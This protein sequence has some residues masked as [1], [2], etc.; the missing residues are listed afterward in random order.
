MA[1]SLR[2]IA[3]LL[4]DPAKRVITRARESLQ[5]AIWALDPARRAAL[6]HMQRITATRP[7]HLALE[8]ND[9]CNARCVFC[10]RRKLPQHDVT[11]EMDLFEKICG[12]Y[13]D[14][15]GGFLGFSPLLADPLLDRLL[16][17]RV[18]LVKLSFP[19]ITLHMFTNAIALPRLSDDDVLLLLRS[20]DH[21]N[22][23]IGGLD[24]ADYRTMFGVDQFENVW[25]SLQR[26]ATLNARE[27]G[28]CKL[29]LHVRTHRTLESVF[30]SPTLAQLRDL[31][32]IC[33][34]VI[35][36][37]ANWGGLVTRDDLP[38]GAGLHPVSSAPRPSTC[39]FPLTYLPIL[40][41]GT[42]LGCGCM[43][44]AEQLVVGDAR[45][46]T[47]RE[48]WTGS[49]MDGLR[50]SF[51]SGKLHPLCRT[52]TYYI[53]HEQVLGHP[54]LRRYNAGEDLWAGS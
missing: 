26:L 8:T 16:V 40:P 41:D 14:L 17:D 47:L 24:A 33:N 9:R 7:L 36:T 54:R 53:P 42:A 44:A 35:N 43:D 18:R 29:L 50:D 38:E 21:V 39:L 4:P 12:E 27:G 30:R 25:S 5:R 52:C 45:T 13:S 19:S 51:A 37:F 15:G 46:S 6:A 49:S 23:S 31:G 1:P 20:L 34:D 22:V 10:A 3:T 48:I 2:R 11:M 32:F 28:H